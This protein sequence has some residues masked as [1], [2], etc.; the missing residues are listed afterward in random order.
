LEAATVSVL[1]SDCCLQSERF[2]LSSSFPSFSNPEALNPLFQEAESE[3]Q[4]TVWP[5]L[6]ATCEATTQRV[7]EGFQRYKVGEEHFYSVTGY[8]HN[9]L[10]R[11]VLDKVFAHAL[12]TEAALVRPHIVSGTHA[13]TL[14][15]NACLRS[16]DL[17]LSLTGPLYD[18]L[19]PV[20]GLHEPISPLSLA[21]RGIRFETIEPDLHHPETLVN[22]E[23]S[24]Q[25][26]ALIRQAKVLYLQR[27]RGY[28]TRSALTLE[29]LTALLEKAKAINPDALV[30]VDNCYGEFVE[31]NEPST[32]GADLLAGSLIKNP[33]GGIVP[34]G[35]YVAG[36]A[37]LVEW[38]AEALT[39]PGIG[40]EGGYLFD[41]T[42]T[43]LQ[44]LFL[45]PNVTKEALKGM[46]LA[47]YLFEALGYPSAPRYDA[48]RSDIIQT[49]F[50]GA[51]TTMLNVCQAI[52][53]A[54]P[55]SSYVRPEPAHIPGYQ[56]KVVMAGGTFI[57]GSSIELSCDGPLREP[58]C[59]YLQGGLTYTHVKL[60]LKQA[61]L[62]IS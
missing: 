11:E 45:A 27:S 37:D 52:Q 58:Y 33:G 60:A 29:H 34:A 16:G 21:G 6:E 44:G 1:V 5:R 7:L 3:L 36:R 24:T 47:A 49:L 41:Q 54:S 30:F 10:G 43:L 62:A 15:L 39:A 18:T 13:I 40:S 61:L 12:Q 8:G 20:L 28:S 46:T 9:D 4:Q 31:A 25:E 35:G 19:E 22:W 56:S 57:D 32:L 59:L 51:E 23:P 26:V 38:A 55:I 48:V 42:R 50:L 2:L 53:Q 14:G 17:L